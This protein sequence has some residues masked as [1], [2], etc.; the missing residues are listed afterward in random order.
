M[1]RLSSG[2]FAFLLWSTA[3]PAHTHLVSSVPSDHA[4]VAVAPKAATLT[5]AEGVILTSAK[6]ESPDG[7][8][9]ELKPLP[10]GAV[11]EARLPLPALPAGGYKLQWRATSDDGH[12]MT[13]E[14]RF[15]VGAAPK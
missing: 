1:R 5:F 14:I 15:V 7:S 2:L 10:E 13:G 11:K 8:K 12:I 4:T 3:V 9:T 6:L